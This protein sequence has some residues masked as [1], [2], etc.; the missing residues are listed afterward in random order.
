LD[1]TI[2]SQGAKE[3]TCS[4]LAALQVERISVSGPLLETDGSVM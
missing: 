1:Y 4:L 2:Y 3:D